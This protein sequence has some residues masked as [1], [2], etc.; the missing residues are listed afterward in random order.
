MT[1]NVTVWLCSCR[2]LQLHQYQYYSSGLLSV[3]D[4]FHEHQKSILGPKK[5]LAKEQ[6]KLE[7]KLKKAAKIK[8][9][10]LQQKGDVEGGEEIRGGAAGGSWGAEEEREDGELTYEELQRLQVEQVRIQLHLKVVLWQLISFRPQR[11]L[12]NLRN[13]RV[14]SHICKYLNSKSFQNA[15]VHHLNVRHNNLITHSLTYSLTHLLT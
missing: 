4:K 13:D 11:C 6:K 8:K 7:K 2:F 3:H 1:I 15:S 9:M 12:R 14:L 5:K 10:K